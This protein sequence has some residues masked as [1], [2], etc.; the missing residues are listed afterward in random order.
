MHSLEI[1][2]NEKRVLNTPF[3]DLSPEERSM[4]FS[5]SDKLAEWNRNQPYETKGSIIIQDRDALL[6]DGIVSPL[7][8]KT[9]FH[10]RRDWANHLKANDCV[11]VGNDFNNSA[12][13]KKEIKGDFDCRNELGH[14]TYQVMDK[15]G[16]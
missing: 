10:N 5:L 1:S 8:G 7:D 2:E 14:A 9:A 16:H 12:Q 4:A 13:K 6:K 3:K 11:E 15:Y